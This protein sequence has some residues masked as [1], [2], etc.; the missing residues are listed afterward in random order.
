MAYTDGGQGGGGKERI[1]ASGVDNRP[2]WTQAYLSIRRDEYPN[3]WQVRTELP[4]V[5]DDDIFESIVGV[6]MTGL[7]QQAPKP[8]ACHAPAGF[9][10]PANRDAP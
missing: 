9:E 7:R 4:E 1:L 6:V 3:I 2:A 10:P 5:R 8:C